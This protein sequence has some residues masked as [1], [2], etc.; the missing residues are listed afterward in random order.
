MS[1][2]RSM[3]S[4]QPMQALPRL[5]DVPMPQT[6][7]MWVGRAFARTTLR[8]RFVIRVEGADLVPRRG[9]V[10]LV[11]NHMG[12]ADGPLLVGL[13]PRPVH[14]L[15]K[16]TMFAGRLGYVLTQAGQISVNRRQLDPRAVKTCLRVLAT[17]GVVAVYPE[18]LRGRG[19]V[20]R[21]RPGA[22]YL[23]LVTGA[24]VV[25]VA[26]LGTREDGA[27]MDSRPPSGARLDLVFGPPMQVAATPWPRTQARVVAVQAEIQSTLEAHVRATCERTG[28]IFPT[29]PAGGS[30][31]RQVLR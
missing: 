25:P 29:M 9:P 1:E 8:R 18:G 22:A 12:Y 26:C 4:R 23:A 5:F 10:I 11:S 28:H 2:P 17:G 21:T 30:H 13:A 15:V 19:D 24:P 31:D 3:I 6:Q 7:W 16:E 14:A 20:R 27:P